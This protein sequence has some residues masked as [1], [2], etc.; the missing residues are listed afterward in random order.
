MSKANT[1]FQ[2]KT[3]PKYLLHVQ[4]G[5]GGEIYRY[6]LVEKFSASDINHRSKQKTDEKNLTQKEI[7]RREFNRNLLID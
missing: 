1:T 4:W 2:P 3:S 5:D 6:A 7:G